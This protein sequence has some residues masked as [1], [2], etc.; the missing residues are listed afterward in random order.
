MAFLN[1]TGVTVLADE[2]KTYVGN[3]AVAKETGKGLSTN[4]YTT[5]EKTKLAGI[6][7]GANKTIVDGSLSSTSTNPV[8]NKVIHTEFG[9]N[10]IKMVILKI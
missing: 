1:E 7:T 8:Q 9:K 4:D 3:T 2:V 5:D 10:L 6:A